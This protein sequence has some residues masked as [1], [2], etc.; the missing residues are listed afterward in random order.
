MK[1]QAMMI[2]LE[3]IPKVDGKPY[4][5]AISFYVLHPDKVP[6]SDR[7]A[8]VK[9]RRK[10]IKG[11]TSV[12]VDTVHMPVIYF[13]GPDLDGVGKAAKDQID[14]LIRMAASV[15]PKEKK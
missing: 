8:Q 11:M 7:S 5:M 15:F 13:A 10:D 12:P 2:S 1:N 14:S 9:T 6:V 4:V 3:N